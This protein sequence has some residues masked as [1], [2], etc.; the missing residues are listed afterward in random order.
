ML[1]KKRGLL[2]A[3]LVAWSTP[4]L[5]AQQLA[6]IDPSGG[7]GVNPKAAASVDD[8]APVETKEG[9][10]DPNGP[11]RPD[12]N[13]EPERPD[14]PRP[15][16]LVTIAR[17][18]ISGYG[19][20]AP[21]L[22]GADLIIRDPAAWRAFWARHTS[23]IDAAPPAPRVNFRHEVVIAAIQGMQTSGGGPRIE[24]L[25]IQREGP[26]DTILVLDDER[27]GPLDVITNPYHLVK[28]NRRCLPCGSVAFQ[29]LAPRPD[30][31]IFSGVVTGG[32]ADENVRR[33][34][35]GAR[36]TVQRQQSDDAAPRSTASGLDG[37][38]VFVNLPPGPYVA[39][40]GKRGF[41]SAEARFIGAAGDRVFRPFFLERIAPVAGG[42]GGHVFGA[43]PRGPVPL[44]RA[45]IVLLRDGEPIE[46]TMSGRDGGYGFRGLEPG[47]YGLV[48]RRE[49]YHPA[50]ELVAVE[51]GEVAR[52]R[53]L[54]RP[55]RPTP[56][57]DP[58]A[59]EP[60]DP[61]PDPNDMEPGRP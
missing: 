45:T 13:G 11:T 10:P 55:L 23:H 46:R 25:G 26:I 39:T 51:A 5:L 61:G 32:N 37:S 29:H 34:M 38:F 24:I 9:R 40:A 52:V 27:G 2:M 31:V 21:G 7:A 50:R 59:V 36:V 1:Q 44:P 22:L 6:T 43:A 20:N 8:V 56:D 17:G 12:P 16:H 30:A 53:F 4:L 48:A 18:E 33:P 15:C 54:L 28:V 58:N 57:P 60:N 3:A 14:R 42:V 41:S 19:Q 47:E 49:G 35:A